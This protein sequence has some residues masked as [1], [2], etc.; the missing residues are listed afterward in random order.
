LNHN[1]KH[2]QKILEYIDANFDGTS[3]ATVPF[4]AIQGVSEGQ[5]KDHLREM[6]EEG[7][8]DTR[9]QKQGGGGTIYFWGLTRAGR[10]KLEEL[11]RRPH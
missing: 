1:Q 2:T 6:K 5:L 4:A 3:R 11:T 7:L 8:L 9:G 10:Q